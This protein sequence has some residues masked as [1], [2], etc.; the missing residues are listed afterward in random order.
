M[1]ILHFDIETIPFTEP[2]MDDITPPANYKSAEAI[3]KF[4]SNPANLKKVIKQRS[5]DL[6][7]S[8]VICISFAL[9]EDKIQSLYGD[10]EE[11]LVNKFSDWYMGA[12]ENKE[13]FT[14]IFS[15]YNC[16][17]FDYPIMA[18][19]LQK[20]NCRAKTFFPMSMRR[21]RFF[22]PLLSLSGLRW[23]YKV[24]MDRLCNFYGLEGKSGVTG[25]DVYDMHKDGRWDDIAKYCESDVELLRNLYFKMS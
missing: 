4:K 21:E 18:L 8:K 7:D 12:M 1:K 13:L 5:V 6:I 23:G 17:E 9:N 10:D 22:D 3:T 20:Y 25:A 11:E 16:R 19:R 15:G 2:T 14:A 24:S